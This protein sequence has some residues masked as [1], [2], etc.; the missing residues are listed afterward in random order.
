MHP[1]P[2]RFG[3]SNCLVSA[4]IGGSSSAAQML[5]FALIGPS[6]HCLNKTCLVKLYGR[7][8]EAAPFKNRERE[9]TTALHH[10][11]YWLLNEIIKALT[12][13]RLDE[14]RSFKANKPLCPWPVSSPPSLHGRSLNR[15]D[16]IWK[17]VGSDH[18]V[19]LSSVTMW[20]CYIRQ[21]SKRE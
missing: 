18:Y 21:A 19:V 10:L 3:D 12:S 11:L 5:T 4:V 8:S 9:W 6:Q 14:L 15:K 2:H 17:M 1:I 7:V 16:R 13:R 20:Q